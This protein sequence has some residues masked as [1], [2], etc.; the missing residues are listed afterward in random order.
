MSSVL[1][2]IRKILV[3]VTFVLLSILLPTLF[4]L[5]NPL[6]YIIYGG[7]VIIFVLLLKEIFGKGKLFDDLFYNLVNDVGILYILIVVLRSILDKN[8]IANTYEIG[9]NML[10]YNYNSIFILIIVIGL[11]IYSILMMMGEKK[12]DRHK[13]TKKR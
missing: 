11:L 1:L 12:N 3:T 6:I 8:I 10:F 4:D 2:S 7:M 9:K 5:R 13:H